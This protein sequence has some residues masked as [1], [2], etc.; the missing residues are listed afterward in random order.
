MRWHSIQTFEEKY[1][2]DLKKNINSIISILVYE[3]GIV[4]WCS[5]CQKYVHVLHKDLDCQQNI[6]K[7][8]AFERVLN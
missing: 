8:G 6:L 4:S 1:S 3:T 7:V 2:Q 5:E